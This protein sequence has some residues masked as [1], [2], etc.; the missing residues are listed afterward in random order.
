MSSLSLFFVILDVVENVVRRVPTNAEDADLID[1]LPTKTLAMR[2]KQIR[3]TLAVWHTKGYVETVVVPVVHCPWP[4]FGAARLKLAVLTHVLCKNLP[5]RDIHHVVPQNTLEL[6]HLHRVTLTDIL[7]GQEYCIAPLLE[8]R[9]WSD[10]TVHR[11]FPVC[12]SLPRTGVIFCGNT[13]LGEGVLV[14]RTGRIVDS[15]IGTGRLLKMLVLD[16]V[17]GIFRKVQ[18]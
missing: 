11:R 8:R 18:A 5:R 3:H 1:L 12:I 15:A 10:P 6:L 4:R 2:V 9:E 17:V 16:C 7:V 14:V 13:T